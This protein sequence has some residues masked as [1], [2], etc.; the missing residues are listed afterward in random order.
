[1]L[2]TALRAY[3]EC[4]ICEVLT[5]VQWSPRI[6]TSTPTNV[7]RTF[8]QSM[9]HMQ[10]FDQKARTGFEFSRPVLGSRPQFSALELLR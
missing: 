5:R 3:C 10:R 8:G 6:C 1:M 9:E 7:V 4:A 2:V